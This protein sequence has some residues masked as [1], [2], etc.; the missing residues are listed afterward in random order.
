[1]TYQ[2]HSC[3][4]FWGKKKVK[5]LKDKCTPMSIIALFTVAK[6]WKQP[7]CLQT[8]KWIKKMWCIYTT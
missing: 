3:V 8:D 4:F 5:M 7:K 1:M 2:F 6:I